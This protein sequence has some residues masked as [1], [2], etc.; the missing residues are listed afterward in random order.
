MCEK[1]VSTFCLMGVVIVFLAGPL[2]AADIIWVD[3]GAIQG[4]DGWRDLLEGDGHTVERMSDMRTLDDA[5]IDAMN[6]ADLVIV[7][8]DTDSGSYDDGEEIDQWNGLAVPL[9]QTSSYLVRSS[10]WQWLNDTTTPEIGA[11]DNML[12]VEDHPIFAGIGSVG[13]EIAMANTATNLTGA[14][15]G[16]NGLV[17]ATHTDGRLW[18]T[19]WEET[20]TSFYDGTSQSPAAARM[21]FAAGEGINGDTKGAMNLTKE[22]Q[23]IFLNAVAYL[24]GE[25]H[26]VNAYGPA[27]KSGT[28]VDDTWTVLS[29]RSGDYAVTHDV[30]IGTDLDDVNSATPDSPEFVQNLGE[31]ELTI[32]RAG[33]VLP[34]GLEPGATYYWRV[35]EINDAND[36]SPWKGDVWSFWVQPAV[37]WAPSPADGIQYVRPDQDLAWEPGMGVLFHT[38][39]FG[40]SFDEV[41]DAAIDG[42]MMVDPTYDPGPLATDKTY[43][44]RVDEF[45]GFATERGELWSFTTLPEVAVTDPS[46]TLWWTLDEGEGFTAVDWSGHGHHGAVNGAAQWT[47]GYQGTALMFGSDVYVEAAD[48]PGVTGTDARTLCAWIRT[49]T[50][51]RTIMSWGQNV[52]GQK[53]RMRLDATG[54]LRTEVNGGYHYGATN[55]A[56]GQWHHVAVTFEDDGSPDATDILL[57]ADGQA[58]ATADSLD[59]PIDT[60]ATGVVR[61]G[62]T[63]WHNAPWVGEID[64]ARIY[65]RVLTEEEIRQVMRGNVLLASNPDPARDATVDIREAIALNWQAGDGAVSHDVYFGA[66][67]EAAAAA[68]KDAAEYRGNQAATSFSLAGLVELGGG[69]YFWRIDEV[70]ADATVQE[71]DVWSFTVPAY[72]IVD[73]FEGYS[74]EVGSR[75]FEV[76]IDGIGFTLPDPG[77]EG[78]GTGAAVGHDIWSSTSPHFD[79]T[80]META[81]VHGGLQ[82][83]PIYYDNTVA[84]GISEADRTFAPPENWTVEG[85]T[86][87]VV[88]FR[89]AA[90]NTGALY[91]EINGVKVAYSGDPADI[92]S[93]QWI[94]WEIDLPSVGVSL[95][96]VSRLT[97]GIEGGQAGVLYVDDIRLTKP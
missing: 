67:R 77:N 28:R 75:A 85:V 27:P 71:G 61:I 40:E 17:L 70:A 74:N 84:P 6:A 3:E 64:D 1:A 24:T 7:S 14:T 39:Y 9:I 47:D 52:V 11:T 95:T 58:D 32:G 35:D 57:Y 91:V 96:S 45:T 33:G 8:R 5:K 13:D 93:T 49:T 86:T 55:L 23:A 46:L 88:H 53:W 41:N 97:I 20:G 12:I 31:S 80:I 89:G 16:G 59:E 54:G 2:F 76:W 78:N 81:N 43:Y 29:W 18:I 30:Y 92:A 51:N 87:L 37:A 62:E 68:D 83:M 63:P 38:L 72:L 42:L 79:G 10:R 36:D 19:L 44:W 66:D 50:A 34:D 65:D 26:R 94:A 48:Y 73:D 90:D 22:G 15:D 82:A 21:W 69:D 60:V 4:F 25:I 56:D